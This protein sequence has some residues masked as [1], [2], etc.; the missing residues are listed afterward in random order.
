MLEQST[1]IAVQ[2]QF[3]LIAPSGHDA[4]QIV[5]SGIGLDLAP[6]RMVTNV[7]HTEIIDRFTNAIA[8]ADNQD[9]HGF[10]GRRSGEDDGR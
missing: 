7:M 5:C 9:A 3:R 10:T 4:E 6:V 8:S 2:T 1:S